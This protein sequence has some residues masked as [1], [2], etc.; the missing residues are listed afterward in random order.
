MQLRHAADTDTGRARDHNEDTFAIEAQP[1]RADAGM[2]FVVC[3]G[4]GGFASGEVAS[5]IA[6]ETITPQYYAARGEPDAA[7]RGAFAEANER[8]YKRGRGKMGTTGVAALFLEDSVLV[9][10]VGD[11]RAYLIRSGELRQITRDHS[12]VEEQVSA[13]VITA[14]Q[15]RESSYRNIITRALGHRPQVEVDLFAEQLLPGDRVLLCSD[16][17]HGQVETDEIAAIAGMGPLDAGVARLIGLANERGGPDNITAVLI[18]VLAVAPAT[19]AVRQHSGTER[20]PSSTPAAAPSATASLPTAERT[21]EVPSAR[22]HQPVQLRGPVTPPLAP[23]R[24]RRGPIVGMILMTLVGLALLGGVVWFVLSTG[25]SNSAAPP[26]PTVP[27][28]T[29]LN[30][31]RGPAS[32]VATATATFVPTTRPQTATP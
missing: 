32:V 19:G 4:M 26:T 27:A 17:L 6:A 25:V 7:L 3:D 23:R 1:E 24:P 18:E 13:G 10:N 15:A 12:F 8:I 14:N 30:A 22:L 2:L 9:A 29:P 31:T 16:G 21:R 20:L 5:S 11:S 28:L